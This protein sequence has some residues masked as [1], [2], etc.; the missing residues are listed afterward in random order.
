M[1]L[2]ADGSLLLI[3]NRAGQSVSVLSVKGKSVKLV[4]TLAIG[5]P[6]ADVAIT[7]DGRRAL[8]VLKQDNKI[9]VLRIRG[10]KVT[11][12][13]KLDINVGISPYNVEI[14]P[15]GNIALVAN[16]GVT[17]GNDGNADTVSVIDLTAPRP[18]VINAVGVGD[19]PEGLAISPK[20]DLAVAVLI[21][22]SQNAKAD[23]A[24]AASWIHSTS[25]PSRLVWRNSR[26]QP[27]S[28]ARA[29]ANSGALLPD[30]TAMVSR[31]SR[32]F[33]LFPI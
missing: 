17:G 12:D 26:A 9:G 8:M 31:Q 1:D 21:N 24:S 15:K 3:A 7:P 4:D 32:L 6:V 13:N 30:T 18:H 20:G 25:S 23:W 16:S 2:N 5:V 28:F 29:A 10:L 11:Y 22:G 19:G 33:M 27:N 14:S